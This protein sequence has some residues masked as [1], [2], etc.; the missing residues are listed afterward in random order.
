MADGPPDEDSKDARIRTSIPTDVNTPGKGLRAA[1]AEAIG[2]GVSKLGSGIEHLGEG[3]EKLGRNTKKIPIV[4][5]SVTALGEGVAS[6]GEVIHELPRAAKTRR[7]QLLIRS[8]I[9]AFTLVFVW[10]AVIVLV[11]L[12]NNDVPDFRPDAEHILAQISTGHDGIDKA[13]DT[14]SPRFQEMV[15]KERFVDDM[16]DM[17]KTL[18]KFHEITAIN[19]TLFT[20]GPTGPIGRVSI[21]AA[22]DKGTCRAAVNFHLDKGEWKLFG[23]QVEVPAELRITQ[24]EREERVQA[25]SDTSSAKTC[26]VR[27]VA[28]RILGQLRDGKAGEVYDAASDVFKKQEER[29]NFVTIQTEQNTELGP[30]KRIV[31]VTEAK[32]MGGTSAIFDVLVER[33]KLSAVRTVFGLSRRSKTEAWQLRLYKVVM[34]MP[35]AAVD[36]TNKPAHK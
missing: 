14:S 16:T 8:M 23:I 5:P 32:V 17:N 30:Y 9:V 36:R 33:E 13:Y 29:A 19:D 10:I 2:E 34:P 7:G 20:T 35:R 31:A 11:Q 1:T 6:V 18:G 24:A 3:I 27:A 28:E 21:T 4:G 15:R 25:C 26:E 12:N 22:F